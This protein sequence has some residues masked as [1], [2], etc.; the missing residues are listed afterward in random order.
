M[1][2]QKNCD[3]SFR[4]DFEDKV[5]MPNFNMQPK[6]H[7]MPVQAASERNKNFNEVALGYDEETAVSEALPNKFYH[8]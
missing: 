3:L 2:S 1:I 7:P 8:L 6:K 4:I 5:I